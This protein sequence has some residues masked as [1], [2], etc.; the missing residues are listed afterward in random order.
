M[1]LEIKSISLDFMRNLAQNFIYFLILITLH[2]FLMHLF[3]LGYYLL[4]FVVLFFISYGVY[5]YFKNI[6]YLVLLPL[7]VIVLFFINTQIYEEIVFE[8]YLYFN[9]THLRI[10]VS[11]EVLYA[12]ML[13]HVIVFINLKKFEKIWAIMNS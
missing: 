6:S 11:S 5:K 2:L 3:I 9:A 1:N 7:L 13:L 4:Y 10:F 8:S 12:L